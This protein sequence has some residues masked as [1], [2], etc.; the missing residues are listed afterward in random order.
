MK[1]CVIGLGYIGL[2]TALMFARQGVDVLGVDINK[3]IIRKLKRKQ[4]TVNEPGMDELLAI[5]M[6]S[7]HLAFSNVPDCAD[8]FIIAVPTPNVPTGSKGCDLTYVLSAIEA[9]LPHVKKGDLIV[10]ES[11]VAPRSLD[12][13][14]APALEKTGL[15]IGR[16]IFLAHC[17][18]R[19]FPGNILSEMESNQRIVGGMTKR[20]GEK[21]KK[22][23][24]VI[25]KNDIIVTDA[26]TAEMTK[27]TENTFRDVNISF[28]NELAKI[29]ATLEINVLDVI[30]YAN[31][32]PRVNV[33]KPGIGV[34]GHCIAVDPYFIADKDRNNS[35]MIQLARAVNNEM[36]EFVVD[37]VEKILKR[38]KNKKIIAWGVTYKADVD[39]VR[40]S[41][42]LEV[43]RLLGNRG[44][45]VSVYDPLIE[46]YCDG[47]TVESV[48]EKNMLLVLVGHK[49]FLELDYGAIKKLMKK[50]AKVFDPSNSINTSKNNVINYGNLPSFNRKTEGILN[51]LELPDLGEVAVAPSDVDLDVSTTAGVGATDV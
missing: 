46:E 48:R 26:R 35:R 4:A 31:C 6:K 2:P 9:I 8:V 17:P 12:D 43:I 1:I 3:E 5:T 45:D 14:I 41:P 39:D 24:A 11:T 27:V 28:A 37:T 50:G 47:T 16:D 10:I 38:N 22:V 25:A 49:Q 13:Y 36:P 42:A 18:E 51:F 44:Y 32:H 15:K 40:E 34:G 19:V 33:M 29:C 20:C 7:G 30:K 21:A 23:Y